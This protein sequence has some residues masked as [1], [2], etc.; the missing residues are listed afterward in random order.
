MA[1]AAHGHAVIRK[2]WTAAVLSFLLGT[3]A[4]IGPAAFYAPTDDEIDA[5]APLFVRAVERL[6][7]VVVL[8]LLLGSGF[9]TAAVTGRVFRRVALIGFASTIALPAWALLDLF[10][11]AP[12]PE[13]HG[14][15]PLELLFYLVLGVFAGIG[16]ALAVVAR[17]TR[18]L[19]H[20]SS[21]P[22]L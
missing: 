12:F 3:I 8:P 13:R 11:G 1:R 10:E 15:L 6:Q 16:A 21:H 4:I 22:P 17:T 2:P 9:M 5:F 20:T 7:P 18:V 19:P 14:V